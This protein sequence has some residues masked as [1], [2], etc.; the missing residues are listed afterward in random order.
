MGRDPHDS[1]APAQD[2]SRGR[3]SR[4]VAAL[5]RRAAGAFLLALLA[6]FALLAAAPA[7]K[8]Q[9]PGA[10]T[11]S[12]QSLQ[13]NRIQLRLSRPA[14]HHGYIR[15]Q[16]HYREKRTPPP[17]W[18]INRFTGT[19]ST[20][21]PNITG[22]ATGTVYEFRARLCSNFNGEGTNCGDWSDILEARTTGVNQRDFQVT[23]LAAAE[24]T[25]PKTQVDLSWTA[26]VDTN[27]RDYYWQS[28]LDSASYSGTA[29][30]TTST[31]ATVSVLTAGTEYDFRVR[32]CRS[33]SNTDGNCGAWVEV[34]HSTAPDIDV[35]DAV[36]DL[37][38]TLSGTTATLTWTVP[39]DG[40]SAFTQ[41][42]MSVDTGG[43]FSIPGNGTVADPGTTAT[44][45]RTST[46]YDSLT[47]FR[48]RYSNA[49][50][51][52]DYSNVATPGP[53]APTGLSG[54][55][56]N[57]TTDVLSWTAP[58]DEG[59][60]A[61]TDHEYRYREIGTS[62]WGGWTSLGTAGTSANAAR[63]G[64]GADANKGY[65][66]QVRAVNAQGPGPGSNTAAVGGRPAG[67]GA[68]TA[69]Q[70]SGVSVDLSWPAPTN[71][72]GKDI[73]HYRVEWREDADGDWTGSRTA[74][75]FREVTSGRTVTFTAADGLQPATTYNFRYL[76]H[77]GDR[78]SDYRPADGRAEATTAATPQL[79][80][81]TG[82]R[83]QPTAIGGFDVDGQGGGW[84]AVPDATGYTVQWKSGTQSYDTSR[85]MTTTSRFAEIRGVAEA[86]E[87]TVRVKATADGFLDG[88]WSDQATGFSGPFAIITGLQLPAGFST[89]D[90]R[91]L[92]GA[93]VTVQ[94]DPGNWTSPSPSHMTVTGVPG[95]T[96]SAIG[97]AVNQDRRVLT[98]AYDGRDFDA[99]LTF[100]LTIAAAAHSGSTA[101]TTD[102]R[103]VSAFVEPTPAQVTGVTLIPGD[104]QLGVTWNAAADATG[105][106][107]QWKSGGQ[108]FGSS[109][110]DTPENPGTTQDPH[111][112]SGL[113]NG[114]E[115][116]V[117]VIATRTNAPDGQPSADATATPDIP[118]TVPGLSATSAGTT[119]D[120]SWT[121]P[122]DTNYDHYFH[123]H[124]RAVETIFGV[125]T[126]TQL[127]GATVSGLTA[128]TDY[129]FQVRACRSN[130]NSN[131]NCGPWAEL[132]HNTGPEISA[133][134][135]VSDLNVTL[136]GTTATLTWTVP[137]DGG[138]AFTELVMSVDTGGGFSIP[139]NGTVANPGTTATLTRTSVNYDSLTKFR[140]RYANAVGDGEYSNVAMAGPGAPTALTGSAQNIT[141]DVLSWTA[142]SDPGGSAVTDHEYR[143][144]EIGTSAW[145]GWTS[146]GT[147]GTSGNAT[148]PGTGTDRNKGFEHQVRAV[149]SSGGGTPSN[150]VAIAGRPGVPGNF[151]AAE[152]SGEVAVDLSWTAPA[153]TGGKALTE[154]RVEWRA[155]ATGSFQ[156]GQVLGSR[157]ILDGSATGARIAAADGLL[158]G[159]DYD[160][161]VRARNADRPGD[162]AGDGGAVGATTVAEP[163]D[164][165]GNF[166]VA[167]AGDGKVRVR[168]G[169]L[170]DNADDLGDGTFER[171]RLQYKESSIDNWAAPTAQTVSNRETNTIQSL[172]LPSVGASYD[173]RLRAESSVANSAWTVVRTVAGKPG[174][175]ATLT[176]SDV[177]ATGATLTWTA[178]TATGGRDLVLYGEYSTD[179]C[180]DP[181]M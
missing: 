66:H 49:Q 113:A 124:K 32:A 167:P 8:A 172:T 142:P 108:S 18:F 156:S 31:S 46:S 54:S 71:T 82:V 81:V 68:L 65:E 16:I 90:E 166:S 78:P 5:D 123:R 103:T 2:R 173:F 51:N 92:D 127:T 38:V 126:H 21:F 10:P 39:S 25:D 163:P 11:I 44:L 148:R 48:I 19:S 47:K 67:L 101:L 7:A 64:T 40:G 130:L 95:L 164:T 100:G 177:T 73:V 153:N 109:R 121:A 87:F 125:S 60:S 139:G 69:A 63:P 43:G 146:L 83:V 180:F 50:G 154:Y 159:T 150:T 37:K 152:V 129:D 42:V 169:S 3:R 105:Y 117:R 102:T 160:F 178:V 107:V 135:A 131:S 116:T 174:T 30:H 76:A 143:S 77:N 12:A 118:G 151:T 23:A 61:V 29:T 168:W 13:D 147:T 144:R 99:N 155:D 36:T 162:F 80:K 122:A 9:T 136:S 4:S 33:A 74:D 176:I 110:E 106:K 120:L 45:S 28:K 171:Y 157:D 98:L 79:G 6:T 26:P 132:A 85:Q 158:G 119:A 89:L 88:P 134:A 145:G 86:T 70:G 14:T 181:P 53:G 96:V 57:I 170:N 84:T 114:T 52:A 133:P 17:I 97:P 115:Y 138:S 149:N 104:R 22:L 41:L 56:L 59:G 94:I 27:Y 58:S 165:P 15:Y 140:I 175:P 62:A 20:N 24:G 141:T 128:N 35:P 72:A 111:V 55:A 137:S 112:V 93:Q 161:R 75:G 91:V 1:R 179:F 34:E